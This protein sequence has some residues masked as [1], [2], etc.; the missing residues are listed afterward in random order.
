MQVTFLGMT[1]LGVNSAAVAAAKGWLISCYDFDKSKLD[2][3]KIGETEYSEPNL[4]SYLSK[5]ES[6]LNVITELSSENLGDLIYISADVPTDSS[7]NSD[8]SIIEAYMLLAT[9][10]APKDAV[11]VVLSQVPPGFTRN[12]Q[13]PNLTI[14]YQVETLIFGRAIERAE[15]PERYI[16][17]LNSSEDVLPK[18]LEAFLID[19]G[20]PPILKMNFE[21]A[22]LA[23]IAIN[24]C[25]VSSISVANTLSEICESI[26]ANWHDISP[27]LRLDQ[28]IG[29][30]SYI[31]P[32]LG[33]SGGNLERDLNSV[34]KLGDVNCTDVQVVEAW[35]NNSKKRKNWCFTVF[36]KSSFFNL[37]DL[38]IAILGLAYKENT[39]S[40]KNSPSIELIEKLADREIWAY[41]PLIN[42]FKLGNIKT[43]F[44]LDQ[45]IFQADVIF[46]M[47]KSEQF[48]SL[49][50][51]RVKKA[52]SNAL[53]VDP[54]GC[55]EH[56]K[57]VSNFK[58]HRI[59]T[60]D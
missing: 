15:N 19:H 33:I 38:K 59:G 54:F 39:N 8:T 11:V 43:G 44:S 20:A 14:A 23:K 58:Y 42:E 40:I 37:T 50:T 47:N 35:L 12:W 28:R 17:G 31:D 57:N 55:V 56:L 26:G 41:D 53:L 52:K 9:N 7:G 24:C 2:K 4:Q 22:E 25:L 21:S 5:N 45:S 60:K 13:K 6:R 16:I 49:T 3:I 18:K 34:L 27:A 51:E 48:C 36:K 29:A 1:H 32:G 10:L 46:V 30:H